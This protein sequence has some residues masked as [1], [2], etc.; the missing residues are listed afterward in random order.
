MPAKSPTTDAVAQS[1]LKPN[2]PT[3]PVVKLF[4]NKNQLMLLSEQ[5][6][7]GIAELLNILSTEEKQI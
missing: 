1:V 5:I 3:N 4:S 7:P 2:L 6:G